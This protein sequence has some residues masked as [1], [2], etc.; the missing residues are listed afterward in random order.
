MTLSDGTLPFLF[1]AWLYTIRR[2]G[3]ITYLPSDLIFET[4]AT[5]FLPSRSKGKILP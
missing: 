5:V 4:E 3:D 1:E 2:S